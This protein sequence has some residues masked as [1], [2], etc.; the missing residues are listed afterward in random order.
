MSI[1]TSIIAV[2]G[3]ATAVGIIVAFIAEK[4]RQ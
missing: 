3:I 2:I 4:N 1:L